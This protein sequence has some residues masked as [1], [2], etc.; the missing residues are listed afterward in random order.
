MSVNTNLGKTVPGLSA[1]TTV[2]TCSSGSVAS[3]SAVNGDIIDRLGVKTRQ[4]SPGEVYNVAEPFASIFSTAG[5]TFANRRTSLQVKLQHGDSSGGGDMADLVTAASTA[6][7]RTLLQW[8]T[9]VSTDYSAAWSTGTVQ[10]GSLSQS[11]NLSQFCKRYL[12]PVAIATLPGNTTGVGDV[13][14]INM[15]VRFSEAY[16]KPSNQGIWSTSTSTS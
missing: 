2:Y 13:F 11:Y 15:G 14:Y 7:G 12:R 16:S 10:M 5:T 9:A 3:G 1:V 4:L 6:P 8:T